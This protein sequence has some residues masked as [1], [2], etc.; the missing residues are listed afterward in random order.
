MKIL[1]VADVY[2]PE[3][4]S[5]ANLMQ[6]LAQ[7]LKQKG[8]DVIVA[9]SYP[10]YYLTKE[11]KEK[12]FKVF[13]EECGIKIIR[14]K[15]LPH[16]KV[17]FIIR[18]ISQLILP[19]IFFKKIKEKIKKIDV[20]IVY[21]P[22]LPLALIGKMIKKKYGAKF[23]LNIQD[24]FPQNAID[25]GILKKRKHKPIIYFFEL[26]EKMVY[27]FADKITFHSEGGRRFLIDKKGIN[28][29]KIITLP[30]WIDLSFYQ[31]LNQEILFRKQWKLQKKFV[32]LFAG[33]IGP[34][35][36]LEFLIKIAQKVS[37][38]KEIVFLLVGDGM[39]KE[40]IKNL[41][42]KHNLKNVIIKPFVS[43]EQYPYLVKE[44]DVCL[45]CLSPKNKTPFTP[46]KFLGYMAAGKPI[47]AFLNKESDAFELINKVGCGYAI[48]SDDLEN[49]VKITEKIYKEKDKLSQFG[50]N[51][52]NYVYNNLSIEVCL[53]K[54]ERIIKE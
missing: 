28:P 49:A 6:E 9:T 3:I 30:N 44:S 19:F 24:I 23:I 37:N 53:N 27:G 20:V 14:V 11:A 29:D 5:A 47:L 38:I 48:A 17:N 1:I 13:S 25:L 15:V 33:I 31:N 10:K 12:S 32:F 21:S 2:P 35:Q 7:G 50:K 18:G 8:Y 41:I 22:P 52:L 26:I 42:K 51:S 45:V 43:K 54:L 36:G 39:E 34:A 16:H 46:G 4:S 40:K